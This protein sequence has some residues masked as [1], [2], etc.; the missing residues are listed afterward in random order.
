MALTL[1]AATATTTITTRTGTRTTTASQ[2]PRRRA[3]IRDT[4]TAR[5]T[6]AGLM[7]TKEMRMIPILI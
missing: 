6:A 3:T 2:D 4:W 5:A 1:R 7:A